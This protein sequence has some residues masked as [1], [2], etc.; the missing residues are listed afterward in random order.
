MQKLVTI[1]LQMTSSGADGERE[2][3]TSYLNDGWKVLSVTSVG[4]GGGSIS[5]FGGWLAVLL[6]KDDVVPAE[7]ISPDLLTN[8][9]GVYLKGLRIRE[10]L[11]QVQLSELTGIPRRHISKMELGKRTI[12]KG[13]AHKL[14]DVLKTD[15]RM[16]LKMET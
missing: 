9:H 13:A 8:P 2:H 4:T 14:A 16:F 6:E 1:G 11:T 3:L 12:G 7:E 15:Y 5:K 10:G